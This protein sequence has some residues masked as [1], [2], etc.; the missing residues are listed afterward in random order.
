MAEHKLNI[1]QLPIDEAPRLPRPTAASILHRVGGYVLMPSPSPPAAPAL[2]LPPPPGTAPC[3][4][5]W[6]EGRGGARED[7]DAQA[8]SA[9]LRRRRAQTSGGLRATFAV[10]EGGG[11]AGGGWEGGGRGAGEGGLQGGAT[12]AASP[13]GAAVQGGPRPATATD[14]FLQLRQAALQHQLGMV[15]AVDLRDGSRTRGG[16]GRGGGLVRARTAAGKMQS[17]DPG[18]CRGVLIRDQRERGGRGL[19]LLRAPKQCSGV[20]VAR[21]MVKCTASGWRD[22]HSHGRVTLILI[23]LMC[24][25]QVLHSS[26]AAVL[27][28]CTFACARMCRVLC[29]Q[30]D[31]AQLCTA[32]VSSHCRPR[33]HSRP[34][35][36]SSHSRPCSQQTMQ[37]I[38]EG[39]S[40]LSKRKAIFLC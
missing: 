16:G 17:G 23:Y 24:K 29:L 8:S 33:P 18:A 6:C 12:R 19:V 4:P 30:N 1:E 38:L 39:Q 14:T 32:A 40:G 11:S 22:Q 7:D 27:C 25:L 9:R 21:S 2:P 5:A 31:V 36:H 15:E 37:G 3:L 20:C 28:R 13:R 10:G 34:C 35:S 26:G